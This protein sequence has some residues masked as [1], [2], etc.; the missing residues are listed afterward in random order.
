M[1]HTLIIG[2]LI[3]K[4]FY[5]LRPQS[6]LL[7]IVSEFI[8]TSVK[9]SYFM[10]QGVG[11]LTPCLVPRGGILYAMIVLGGFCRLRVVSQGFVPEVGMVL[12]EIDS[13][14]N[15]LQNGSDQSRNE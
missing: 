2:L 1:I 14:I 13:C 5:L 9:F 4:P 12:D 15:G 6:F 10:S 11:L 8:N 7:Q 3:E